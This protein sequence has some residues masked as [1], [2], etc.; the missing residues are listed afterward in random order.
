[1]LTTT[2][3][4]LVATAKFSQRGRQDV[5]VGAAKSDCRITDELSGVAQL[6][7]ANSA[8]FFLLGPFPGLAIFLETRASKQILSTLISDKVDRHE[9]Y[10]IRK[11][12]SPSEWKACQTHIYITIMACSMGGEAAPH[13]SQNIQRWESP[14]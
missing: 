9:G 10:I 6:N 11:G 8:Q 4:T 13:Q 12:N 3:A 1:V 5:T 14:L 7:M 2:G